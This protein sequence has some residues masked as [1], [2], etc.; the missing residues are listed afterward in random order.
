[1]THT[2]NPTTQ[3]A[4]AGSSQL[5]LQSEF[6]DIQGYTEKPCVKKQTNKQTNKQTKQ[7]QKARYLKKPILYNKRTSGG[8]TI[9]C[10]ELYYREIV[11]KTAWHWHKNRHVDQ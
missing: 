3:E 9:P 5:G 10:F 4:Q 8:I 11:I 1:M 6:Q 2:F 7:N